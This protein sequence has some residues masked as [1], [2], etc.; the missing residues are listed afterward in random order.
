MDLQITVE[1]VVVLIVGILLAF[2]EELI[3]KENKK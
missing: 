2:I 1:I 3:T